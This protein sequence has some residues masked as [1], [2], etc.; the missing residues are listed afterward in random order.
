[1]SWPLLGA[2]EE[3]GPLDLNNND[4]ADESDVR[5]EDDVPS[6]R[7]VYVE[8]IEYLIESGFGGLRKRH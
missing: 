8:Y 3:A 5:K 6:K 4:I 7:I 1:M 2:A